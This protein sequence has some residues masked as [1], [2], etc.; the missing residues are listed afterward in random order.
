MI[1]IRDKDIRISLSCVEIITYTFDLCEGI[2][3]FLNLFFYVRVLLSSL[4]FYE[5]P[6]ASELRQQNCS[7]KKKKSKT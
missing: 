5:S 7:T 2:I 1:I 6:I 3:I 4:K